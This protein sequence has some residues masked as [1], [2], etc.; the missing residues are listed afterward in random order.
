MAA[1]AAIQPNDDLTN[2]YIAVK[3]IHRTNT[4]R[5]QLVTSYT[6]WRRSVPRTPMT[7][8]TKSRKWYYWMPMTV[9]LIGILSV[10]LLFA[11]SRIRVYQHINSILNDAILHVEVGTS[12]FHLKIEEFISGD[13]TVN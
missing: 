6:L 11:I 1:P 9:F 12:M 7:G 5:S 8:S 2:A 4:G 13:T 3:I 10:A